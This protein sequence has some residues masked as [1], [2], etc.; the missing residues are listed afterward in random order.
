[1]ILGVFLEASRCPNII[2]MHMQTFRR[3]HENNL[4]Q[5]SIISR[6]RVLEQEKGG[7]RELTYIKLEGMNIDGEISKIIHPSHPSCRCLLTYYAVGRGQ[8]YT[9][10]HKN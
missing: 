3:F 5:S 2:P 7:A 4:H 10:H 9:S 1:M 8:C 6:Y